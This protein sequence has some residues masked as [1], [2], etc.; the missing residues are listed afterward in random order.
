MTEQC[1][2]DIIDE[3]K[4]NISE[5][6]Y[7]TMGSNLSPSINETGDKVAY[8]RTRANW[9]ED[10]YDN[11]LFVHD[12]TK[13]G[14]IQLTRGKPVTHFEWIG[15]SVIYSAED[16]KGKIQVWLLKDL[17]GHPLQLTDEKEGIQRFTCSDEKVVVLVEDREKFRKKQREEV[18]GK[19]VNVEE[20]STGS[21]ILYFDLREMEEFIDSK[22]LVEEKDAEPPWTNLLEDF[23]EPLHVT[24]LFLGKQ[25][26]LISGSPKPDLI[27]ARDRKNFVVTL[28]DRKITE[29]KLPRGASLLSFS[30]DEKT[31]VV[32][33]K[34]R[35]TRFYTQ[36]DLW[37]IAL[38]ELLSGGTDI[39]LLTGEIDQTIM[40][41]YWTN[42]GIVV[43]FFEDT[44][45]K[46]V[47]LSYESK[48][49]RE[50]R[51]NDGWSGLIP[52]GN[53]RGDFAASVFAPDRPP[54]IIYKVGERQELIAVP[55][56]EVGRVETMRWK[57]RDGVEIQGVVRYPPNYDDTQSYP[58]A[59]IIHGGPA[60]IS[61][62]SALMPS[63]LRYYPALQLSREGVIIVE[64]NYRGS[65]GRGQEFLE[66]NVNNL[67]VGDLWDLESCIDHLGDRV[68]RERVFAMGWSQGG[69]ISA[70]AATHSERF[71]AVSV[72]A[73][74]SDWYSY[75]VTTDIRNFTEDY[76]S[77][78]PITDREIYR[79][80]SPM[81]A[82]DRAKTP[83]LIQIGQNDQRVPLV[84]ATELYRA[85]K[86]KGVET[87]LFVYPGMPHGIGKPK[88]NL[89]VI[90][91]NYQWFRHHLT[92]SELD[93]YPLMG[94]EEE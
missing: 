51:F 60:W 76:L 63:H 75:W 21:K 11:D 42:E 45:A 7:Y 55:D 58:L 8:I 83:T 79:K 29:V 90:T 41:H 92:G 4:R 14:S 32:H 25:H 77:A 44:R 94:E 89:A 22:L 36:G 68:D 17:V 54:G 28:G 35:D 49:R 5:P 66:L 20:E 71:T 73:G 15:S 12:I 48:E 24:N 56:I 34:K 78:D 6:W 46:A 3:L 85:L 37:T 59:F 33:H 23:D 53:L 61:V 82:I 72:G 19:F 69:Y 80:T 88:E 93:F 27:Y 50:I 86:V 84:N 10:R 52:R 40:S 38:D 43:S 70:M 81:S 57:S 1:P 65:I 9:K 16:D 13:G 67:G 64:P 26:L 18:Y 30:P 87:H 47:I 31:V 91:Q 2:M 62:E 74:I 39:D